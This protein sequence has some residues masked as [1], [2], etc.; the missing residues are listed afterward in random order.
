MFL[1]DSKHPP[2]LVLSTANPEGVAPVG[3]GVS[4]GYAV[5]YRRTGGAQ[6]SMVSGGT[7][8][9]YNRLESLGGAEGSSQGNSRSP[10]MTSKADRRA[11]I[12][13]SGPFSVTVPLHI[14]SGLALG[15]LQGGWNEKEQTVQGDAADDEQAETEAEGEQVKGSEPEPAYTDESKTDDDDNESKGDP[16]AQLYL[17]EMTTQI[18][19]E[20]DEE[21]VKSDMTQH[22]ETIERSIDDLSP[23]NDEEEYMGKSE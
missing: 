10:G 1:S 23:Q 2:A 22:K 7:Q 4:S 12:H 21:T 20:E 9:T 6:V 15:V 14:T 19:E 18:I 5:T 11:G 13:I 3:G 16:D 8:G 17:G